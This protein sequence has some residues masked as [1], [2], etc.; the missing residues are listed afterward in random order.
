MSADTRTTRDP[1][2][3][4]PDSLFRSRPSSGEKQATIRKID[5]AS[6]KLDESFED[7]GDPYNNTGRHLVAAKKRRE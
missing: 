6:L 5:I 1:A 4:A 7:D 3:R 2:S